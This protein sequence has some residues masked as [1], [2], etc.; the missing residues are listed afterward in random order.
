MVL[1]RRM[2]PGWRGGVDW[3]GWC[4][5][6]RGSY[7]RPLGKGGPS[8]YIVRIDASSTAGE[9]RLDPCTAAR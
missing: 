8:G 2:E 4:G 7:A 1:V 6:W 5:P 3:V 9:A